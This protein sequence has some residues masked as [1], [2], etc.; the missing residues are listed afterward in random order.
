MEDGADSHF[1]IDIIDSYEKAEVEIV[2]KDITSDIGVPVIAAFSRDMV[3]ETMVPIDGFGAH[4]D[5]K[6]A[7]VRALLEIATTRA[8]FIDKYGIEGM[9]ESMC[10]YYREEDE[11]D[12]RFYASDRKNL[13]D[14][15]VEYTDDIYDDIQILMMKLEARGLDRVIAVDLTRP[16]LGIPTVRMVVPGAEASCF[17][18]SRRGERLMNT[19]QE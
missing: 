19:F 2:A 18:K 1:I 15:A 17:D 4:L 3:H 16:D 13:S 10:A 5:P 7:M 6:V 9:Q 12:P 14:I 8:L 11:T